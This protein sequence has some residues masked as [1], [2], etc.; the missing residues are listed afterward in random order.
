M[1]QKKEDFLQDG[2]MDRSPGPEVAAESKTLLTSTPSPRD[3]HSLV[4]AERILYYVKPLR[5]GRECFLS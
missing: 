3:P 4:T 2:A 5:L 1:T